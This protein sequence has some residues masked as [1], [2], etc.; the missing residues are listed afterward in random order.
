MRRNVGEKCVR[1]DTAGKCKMRKQQ[2]GR[3]MMR[4]M[5]D[6]R[7]IINISNINVIIYSGLEVRR[8]K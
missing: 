1:H 5:S 7:I 2:R 4:P 6:E 8:K 3:S